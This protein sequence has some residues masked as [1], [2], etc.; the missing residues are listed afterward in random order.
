MKDPGPHW[1]SRM[2][3]ATYARYSAQAFLVS[4][5]VRVGAIESAINAAV[6]RALL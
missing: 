1:S 3:L 4:L 6:Y 5:E 2:R